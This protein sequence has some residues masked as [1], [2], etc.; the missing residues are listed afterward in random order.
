M[1]KYTLLWKQIQII[2]GCKINLKFFS[3]N[4]I[5]IIIIDDSHMDVSD[6]FF[7]LQNFFTLWRWFL[8]RCHFSFFDIW[9]FFLY[10]VIT[11]FIYYL[12]NY[13]NFFFLLIIVIYMVIMK[14]VLLVFA[15]VVVVNSFS[16]TS[17]CVSKESNYHHFFL[18]HHHHH[19]SIYSAFLVFFFFQNVQINW[20]I[21]NWINLFYKQTNKKNLCLIYPFIFPK[22]TLVHFLKLENLEALLIY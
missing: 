21:E 5:I 22:Q 17:L 3:I 10:R 20:L 11:H 15:V 16:L 18:L 13:H 19:H 1:I 9:T 12:I 8:F 6:E 14:L 7:F 2:Y 4:F